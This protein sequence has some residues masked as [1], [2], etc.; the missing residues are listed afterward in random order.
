[1]TET[2]GGCVH[3]GHPLSG[4]EL[5]IEGA[6]A[7]GEI[8][9]RGPVMLGYLGAPDETARA[10]TV[11]GALRTGDVGFLDAEGALHVV[12]RL[13]DLV[14]SG[15]VNVSPSVVESVLSSDPAVADVAVIGATDDEWGERVV[16]CVVP[17][18]R[19]RPP[20]LAELQD[21]VRDRL[22]PSELPR[23]LRIVEAIPRTGSGKIRRADLSR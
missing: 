19:E 13:K 20:V 3:D 21:R 17:A 7:T 1:M 8:L 4:V 10:F 11:D 9:V 12:D 6:R 22:S 16:A 14:I 5:A 2:F 23:E 15:G 18:D